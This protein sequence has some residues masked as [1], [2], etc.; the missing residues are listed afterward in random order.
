[1]VKLPIELLSFNQVLSKLSM[2]GEKKKH[3]KLAKSV[4]KAKTINKNVEII[5]TLSWLP[6]TLVAIPH[7]TQTWV[8]FLSLDFFLYHKQYGPHFWRH[9]FQR[10]QHR[11]Q[12]NPKYLENV[13]LDL[14]CFQREK[15]IGSSISFVQNL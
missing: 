3:N 2:L 7:C 9:A 11:K 10:I 8:K 4:E 1:M 5:L 13:G 14:E 15:R 6:K 12:L